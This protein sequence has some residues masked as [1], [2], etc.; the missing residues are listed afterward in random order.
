MCVCEGKSGQSEG[1][2]SFGFSAWPRKGASGLLGVVVR[3]SSRAQGSRD[4]Q[5]HLAWLYEPNSLTFKVYALNPNYLLLTIQDF[6]T[7]IPI[8]RINGRHLNC[9][10]LMWT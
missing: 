8:C 9:Q 7:D 1:L 2:V 3:L 6:L 5:T 4:S 10:Q